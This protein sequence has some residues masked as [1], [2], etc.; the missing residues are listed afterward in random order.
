MKIMRSKGQSFT[1]YEADE[2]TQLHL[3]RGLVPKL[4][5]KLA[6]SDYPAGESITGADLVK[7]IGED[8]ALVLRQTISVLDKVIRPPRR[9]RDFQI[10][11]Y[12]DRARLAHELWLRVSKLCSDDIFKSENPVESLKALEKAWTDRAHP[13]T[14]DR[15]QPLNPASDDNGKHLAKY[16]K[17]DITYDQ[18]KGRWRDVFWKTQD[19]KP[20]YAATANAVWVHLFDQER[21]LD[22]EVKT[23]LGHKARG[24]ENRGTPVPTGTG[25]IKA[26]GLT[27]KN[28]ANDPRHAIRLTKNALLDDASA[29]IDVIYFHDDIAYLISEAFRA[30]DAEDT[31]FGPARKIG[32]LLYKH[33]SGVLAAAT[34]DDTKKLVWL[35]HNQVRQFYQKIVRTNRF[36][37]AFRTRDMNKLENLLPGDTD[38][39]V[40]TLDAKAQNSDL[41][42][43]IRL[44]KMVAH[45][46]D[47]TSLPDDQATLQCIFEDRLNYFST[48]A[49]QSEIKRNETFTRLWRT[50]V[51]LSLRTLS[52]WLQSGLGASDNL[53][54]K[55]KD[56]DITDKNRFPK[57]LAKLEE[58][59]KKK[60]FTWDHLE[61]IFGNDSFTAVAPYSRSQ[62]FSH[63]A[64]DMAPIQSWGEKQEIIWAL[65]RL[66]TVVRNATNHFNVRHRLVAT[67]CGG[68]LTYSTAE[69]GTE[70]HEIFMSLNRRSGDHIDPSIKWRFRTL[71]D[72]DIKL[73]RQVL[74]DDLNRLEVTRY[75]TEDRLNDLLAELGSFQPDAEFATPKFMPLVKRARNLARDAVW[76]DNKTSQTDASEKLSTKSLLS[77]GSLELNDL[78]KQFSGDNH[79]RIGILRHLYQTGFPAW[80]K[81]K[82]ADASYLRNALREVFE[83]RADREEEYAKEQLIVAQGSLFREELETEVLTDL[84]SLLAK[85]SANAAAGERQRQNANARSKVRERVRVAGGGGKRSAAKQATWQ[86]TLPQDI[87][88][89][90]FAEYLEEKFDWIWEIQGQVD[91]DAASLS[92]D[93]I[94]SS[95]WQTRQPEDWE[96]Q[97]YTWLYLVP[98]DQVSLLRHQFHKTLALEEAARK[99]AADPDEAWED[100]KA[101]LGQMSRLMALFSAVQEAGFDGNEHIK[102]Y[103]FDLV[104]TSKSSGRDRALT[105]Q[106]NR[107]DTTRSGQVPAPL[108]AATIGAL[109]YANPEQFSS[110]HTQ[111]DSTSVVPGTRRGLRQVL[112][113]GHLSTVQRIFEKHTISESEVADLIAVIEGF[114]KG[115]S[116]PVHHI[117]EQKKKLH[118][119][120]EDLWEKRKQT[121]PAKR[122]LNDE[123]R[124]C[125]LCGDYKARAI[126]TA[127][128]NFSIAGARLTDHADLHH[129]MMRVVARLL[130]FTL[131]WERDRHYLYLGMLC[132]NRRTVEKDEDGKIASVDLNL[133]LNAFSHLTTIDTTSRRNEFERRFVCLDFGQ[134]G[135]MQELQVEVDQA[136][137]PQIQNALAR[138][139]GL[140]RLWDSEMGLSP[141]GG[142]EEMAF[143]SDA[144]AEI[145][146]KYFVGL[147]EENEKDQ[148]AREAAAKDKPFPPYPP[149]SRTFK[150]SKAQI[151][152][153]FAHFNVLLKGRGLNLSYLTNAVRSL[154]SYDRKLK[155]VVSAAIADIVA[156]AGLEVHWEFERDRLK[157][158]TIIPKA[159]AHLDW[160]PDIGG[161]DVAFYL[162]A[163]SARF[164]SMVKAL[165]DFD[166]EG[167]IV[168]N[169]SAGE[170]MGTLAY[171]DA[172]SQ[173][174]EVQERNK[175]ASAGDS[176]DAQIRCLVPKEILKPLENLPQK[177]PNY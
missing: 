150:D 51:A 87:Y 68:L 110:I 152:N 18:F 109:F 103:G 70:A 78:S 154:V 35:R 12:T 45:A 111:S 80:L 15:V 91:S 160:L 75:V 144:H 21:Q 16:G 39:L 11:A 126:E 172:F 142:I 60:F 37:M 121:I 17:E 117:F 49:G 176:V 62:I 72:F 8:H 119:N 171:P 53:R 127:Q 175:P 25:L 153:D 163:R 24:D 95:H 174:Y 84:S 124:L 61:L 104:S 64:D 74:L 177:A 96:C 4:Q 164:T 140:V 133:K 116:D 157:N 3:Q 86:S 128:Y 102:A 122:S 50:S 129:L 76:P 108:D 168:E 44:G 134:S 6:H 79:F 48:S 46:A 57:A 148:H 114:K 166:S 41:S 115:K 137:E 101:K 85:L 156:D 105:A 77:F 141:R 55:P 32:D 43:L 123:M 5:R 66:A 112:K 83:A 7:F 170:Q 147:E 97:F 136:N 100:E 139:L 107:N 94:P 56:L 67:V 120:I 143:I 13:Y 29:E 9:L 173:R 169:G 20:D 88:G 155:N 22:G 90:L 10:Q 138:Q 92:L 73:Q 151:R 59:E 34:D 1:D 52:T 145:F 31:S 93:Q 65:V 2:K 162:P 159:V 69:P 58:S 30:G 27:I 149:S 23:K 135:Y 36:K 130:D 106:G 146:R 158:P 131:T 165:F 47:I 33:M 89:H 40:R 14:R 19:G 81:A 54:E 82:E 26:R 38:T 99:S 71:L 167:Y 125:E 132:D 118:K 161:K 98:S 28:S 42:E 113:F 63:R